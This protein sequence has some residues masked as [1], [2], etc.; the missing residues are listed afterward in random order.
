MTELLMAGCGIKTCRREQ[1]W[2]IL[3]EEM[4]GIF[5]TADG[6]R[7]EKREITRYRRY[8]KNS[9]KNRSGIRD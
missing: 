9:P 8:T 7:D 1:D 4:R 2:L 5:K 3:T 6:M